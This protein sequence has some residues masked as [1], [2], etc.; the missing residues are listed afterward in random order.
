VKEN[1]N[2]DGIS[3]EALRILSD[4]QFPIHLQET[5]KGLRCVSMAEA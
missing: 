3:Q 2:W 4:E 1:E 5:L